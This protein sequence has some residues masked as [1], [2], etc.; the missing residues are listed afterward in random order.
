MTEY[1]GCRR[2]GSDLECSCATTFTEC[3]CLHDGLKD[4]NERPLIHYSLHSVLSADLSSVSSIVISSSIAR[5]FA[6]ERSSR[7]SELGFDDRIGTYLS[8]TVEAGDRLCS[9]NRW[10]FS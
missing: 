9:L 8:I 5:L 7:T 3:Y 2:S 6:G 4:P 1:L 10:H